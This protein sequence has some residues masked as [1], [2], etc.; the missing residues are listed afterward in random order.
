MSSMGLVNNSVRP[1]IWG[2]PAW[3]FFHCVA[4]GYP[5]I[6]DPNDPSHVEK[7]RSTI[8][9]FENV[10]NCLP[11]SMC[12]ES[13]PQMFIKND[14]NAHLDSRKALAEW[15]YKLNNLVKEKTN[16]KTLMPFN[17]FL[18]G[19]ESLMVR[20]DK[21]GTVCETGELYD[22][23]VYLTIYSENRRQEECRFSCYG[24]FV[25][26]ILIYIFYF[27]WVAFKSG[28]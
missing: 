24:I 1:D 8:A 13:Y 20:C 7:R 2:P 21:D 17:D 16:S 15:V 23:K 11:C 22:A 6:Y 18:S 10:G 4:A 27:I 28:K 12:R 14:I 19:I 26:I 3:F 5:E 9:F 25:F